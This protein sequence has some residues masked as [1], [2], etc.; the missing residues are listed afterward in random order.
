MY[1]PC[2]LTEANVSDTGVIAAATRSAYQTLVDSLLDDWATGAV[3]AQPPVPLY[4]GHSVS[5]SG[6]VPPPTLVT[7]LIVEPIIATQRRRLRR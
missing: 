3:G 2:L 1:V 6:V 7:Q 5:G 4:L